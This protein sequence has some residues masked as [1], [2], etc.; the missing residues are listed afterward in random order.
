[1]PFTR[2]RFLFLFIFGGLFAAHTIAQST[3]TSGSI[4]GVVTDTSGAVNPGSQ[5]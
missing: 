2:Y 5:R 4:H 1:M 3:G